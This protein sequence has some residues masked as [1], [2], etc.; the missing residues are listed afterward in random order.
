LRRSLRSRLSFL[1][2]DE[3]LSCV[4]DLCEISDSHPAHSSID[5]DHGALC[6][7]C[8][9]V[10]QHF[11]DCSGNFFH[12]LVFLPV[13]KPIPTITTTVLTQACPRT[14]IPAIRAISLPPIASSRAA[15]G[16]EIAISEYN[17]TSTGRPTGPYFDTCLAS[18]PTQD[19]HDLLE[20]WS[21]CSNVACVG[22]RW[23]PDWSWGPWCRRTLR[24]A[25]LRDRERTPSGSGPD[26]CLPCTNAPPGSRPRSCDAPATPSHREMVSAAGFDDRLTRI[27]P[28]GP[29]E[30][31]S[32]F[33]VEWR[34][35]IEQVRFGME[36]AAKVNQ[37]R[38]LRQNRETSWVPN[39]NRPRRQNGDRKSGS[40]TSAEYGTSTWRRYAGSALVFGSFPGTDNGRPERAVPRAELRT[41]I[42]QE[43]PEQP[44]DGLSARQCSYGWT[45]SR[46]S[47]PWVRIAAAMSRTHWSPV[48]R[49]NGVASAAGNGKAALG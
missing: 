6:E 9:R 1:R 38:C 32:A 44:T 30:P 27:R 47:R 29:L 36:L 15:F 24:G 33:T 43:W 41:G 35:R 17:R 12:L 40:T 8:E 10:S 28:P 25:L 14:W 21:R 13:E 46:V 16:I 4:C 2:Q 45:G 7:L 34:R 5:T 20:K 26:L 3:H 18:F 42:G 37:A 31:R 23:S 11:L 22:S 39:L 49:V 48:G 19:G